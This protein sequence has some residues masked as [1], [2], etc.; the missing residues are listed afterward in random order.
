C[1]TIW[2]SGHG[3]YGG[4]TF[5]FE[6]FINRR[7]LVPNVDWPQTFDGYIDFLTKRVSNNQHKLFV[8]DKRCNS[9]P[10]RILQACEVGYSDV[11]KRKTEYNR[12]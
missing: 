3:P 6:N 4:T 11:V 7:L 9:I 5:S 2:G 1:G 8:V 12:L 10:V